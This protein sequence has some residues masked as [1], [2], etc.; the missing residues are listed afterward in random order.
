MMVERATTNQTNYQERRYNKGPEVICEE[1]ARR[2]RL[3]GR[4]AC[5]MNR[6]EGN[7]IQDKYPLIT[8]SGSLFVLQ[9]VFR[10]HILRDF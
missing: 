6:L 5:L 2:S 4:D 9:Q 1:T 10:M 7:V 3:H 8:Y